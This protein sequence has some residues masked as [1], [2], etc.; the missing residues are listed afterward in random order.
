MTRH[1]S[2]APGRRRWCRR[3]W[4]AKSR[5]ICG[6]NGVAAGVGASMVLACDLIVA[7][8][9]AAS[10]SFSCA[11]DSHPT[12]APPI[13]CRE[14]CRSMSPRSCCFF[15]EELSAAE[16]HRIGLVNKV[17]AD[18]ELT[19]EVAAWAQRLARDATRGIG[20]RQSDA[21]SGTRCRSRRGLQCRGASRG[22]GRGTDDVA[23]GVAAFVEHRDPEFRGR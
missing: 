7:A 10:S 1:A 9:S 6:L 20:G 19:A 14:R 16:A 23:E 11:E 12:E 8:E 2:C 18:E 4:I 21:E 17:V 3:C 15:G 5:C 22:P 13:C